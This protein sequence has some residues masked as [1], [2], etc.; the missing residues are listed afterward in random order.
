MKAYLE[1]MNAYF[2]RLKTETNWLKLFIPIFIEMTIVLELFL[3]IFKYIIEVVIKNNEYEGYNYG[4]ALC[5]S[6]IY[7]AILA[8]VRSMGAKHIKERSEK[9]KT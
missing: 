9:N 6:V 5:V 2:E 1:K 4:L 7:S 8:G 3:P